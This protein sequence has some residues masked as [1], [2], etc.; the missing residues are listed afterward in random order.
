FDL[1]PGPG[2]TVV[3]CCRVAALIEGMLDG[4]GLQSVAKT[5]GSKGLQ[6]YVP[7]NSDVGY[8]QT[9]GFARAVAETLEAAEP[10]LVTSRMTKSVRKGRV[11]ID[12]SQNDAHKTTV[13]VYSPRA[14]E[15]PTV[16]TPLRWDEVRA[17]DDPDALSFDTHD[18]L[19]RVQQHGD[20]FAPVLSLA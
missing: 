15:R 5:S 12:W 2:A 4:L 10:K 18:V 8:E 3:E 9:K 6:V 17:C 20:L 11:F 16:S 14:M 7:L 13:N 19:A 1:D